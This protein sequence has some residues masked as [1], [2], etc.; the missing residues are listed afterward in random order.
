M[1]ETE[2]E[3]PAV[4]SLARASPATPPLDD[5]EQSLLADIAAAIERRLVSLGHHEA[6]GPNSN[7]TF[8]IDCRKRIKERKWDARRQ[9]RV[10][11]ALEH[12]YRDA[13]WK[14]VSIYAMED[15]HLRLRVTLRS[16]RPTKRPVD[17]VPRR[18]T[19]IDK[20]SPSDADR[21]VGHR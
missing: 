18:A 4:R 16:H 8:V 6:R 19:R 12:R 21:P 15:T 11:A 20:R 10:C 17:G 5:E 3:T 1:S 14:D 13:G 9:R 2:R 7:V